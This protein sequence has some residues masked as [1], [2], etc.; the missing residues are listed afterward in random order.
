MGIELIFYLF[1][2]VFFFILFY[3]RVKGGGNRFAVHYENVTMRQYIL[4]VSIS[5]GYEPDVFIESVKPQK[6]ISP[7]P[8][9]FF[10]VAGVRYGGKGKSFFNK[11]IMNYDV[12]VR[13]YNRVFRKQN[14]I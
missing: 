2:T 5:Y 6:S 3:D 13:F 10:V 14:Q 9:S 7:P 4:F 8:L 12:V 11:E 1:I